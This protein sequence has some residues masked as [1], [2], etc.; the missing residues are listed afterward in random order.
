MQNNHPPVEVPGFGARLREW[1]RASEYDLDSA[2]RLLGVSGNYLYTVE[3][4][5]HM[6]APS[7]VARFEE[8]LAGISIFTAPEIIRRVPIVSWVQ[9]GRMQNY[10]E[11][12]EGW[13]DWVDCL[14]PDPKAFAVRVVGDS[15]MPDHPPGGLAVVMPSFPPRNKELAVAKLRDE[16]TTFKQVSFR[17]S[18]PASFRLTPLNPE[19]KPVTVGRDD[20]F[21]IYPVHSVVSANNL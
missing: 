12:P 20:L 1:R 2:A 14:C 6:A 7:L 3:R 10:E 15:M 16:T 5:I 11:M 13:M 18:K 8:L 19:F 9:A 4:G 17:G 21:W